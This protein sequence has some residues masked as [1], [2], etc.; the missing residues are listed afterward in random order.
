VAVAR[1]YRVSLED[2]RPTLMTTPLVLA[3]DVVFVMEPW[4]LA[5]LRRR[6]PAQRARFFLLPRFAP[7]DP[8]LGAFERVHFVDPFG[9]GEPAFVESY[10]RIAQA[11]ERV[12]ALCGASRG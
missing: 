5:Q 4:Q 6:W 8:A 3:H 10:G 1:R 2:H 7:S 9:R 11:V 12:V